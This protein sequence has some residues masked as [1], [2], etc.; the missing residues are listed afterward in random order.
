ML[1]HRPQPELYGC[2]YH[3][4]YAVTHDE[5]LLDHVGDISNGRFYARLH[6]LGLMVITAYAAALPIASDDW[7]MLLQLDGTT[8]LLTID[9][10]RIPGM[11]H[12]VAAEVHALGVT[13]S[14]SRRA[15][16]QHFT[17]A[18]F[19]ASE[20]AAAY[21]VEAPAPAELDAYPH[22]DAAAAVHRALA[23]DWPERDDYQL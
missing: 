13:V 1:L 7:A 8:F 11:C 18:E 9:A 21:R 2:M 16:L 17:A 20:Y 4:A 22:E 3:A 5:S 10:E 6:G 19:L 12:M 23:Q 15:G 14:D